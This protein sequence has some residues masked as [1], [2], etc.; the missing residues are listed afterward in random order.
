VRLATSPRAPLG[1]R[2]LTLIELIVALTIFTV[3]AYSLMSALSLSNN[4]RA[5]V[6]NM[7]EENEEL[8]AGVGALSEDLRLS[9]EARITITE[10]ADENHQLELQLPIVVGGA[11][12]WGV[13]GNQLPTPGAVAEQDW[14]VRYTVDVDPGG[15]DGPE[16]T[17]VRQVVDDAG[18]IVAEEVLVHDLTK[19][20][21]ASPGFHIEETGEVW[22]VTLS[23][24]KGAGK[25]EVFHVY[26]RN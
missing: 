6:E 26:S 5:A 15:A 8:R 19:G 2:G 25:S 16:R 9:S 7:V 1:R 3:L 24:D 22:E 4:S 14:L 11:L 17:L 12:D 18:K 23:T 20:T 13:P 21:S 10:L